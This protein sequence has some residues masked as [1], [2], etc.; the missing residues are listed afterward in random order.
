[1]SESASIPTVQEFTPGGTF[2]FTIT[3]PGAYD[4]TGKWATFELRRKD[5]KTILF[6][7]TSAGSYISLAGTT[8][9]IAIPFDATN[10]LS[11]SRT[12]G[13]A[14]D[15]GLRMSEDL[16]WCIDHG[17]NGDT[18]LVEYRIQGDLRALPNHGRYTAAT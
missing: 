6:R 17:D 12:F 3:W 2:A 10:D 16:V 7:T 1:M 13:D 5:E 14:M 9:T 15:L 18:D 11:G 8:S 4:L